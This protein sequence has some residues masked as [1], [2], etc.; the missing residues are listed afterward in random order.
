MKRMVTKLFTV[1]LI[2]LALTSFIKPKKWFVLES[3]QYG[4]KIEFPRKPSESPQV[5]NSAI[6][7]LK[8]NIF[9]YDASETGKDDNLVYMV[10]YTEYPD[11]LINSENTEILADFFRNSIDGAVTNVHGK[12]L[13]LISQVLCQINRND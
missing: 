2:L 3:E 10:S 13:S 4:Y 7:E 12:L 11:T 5:V 6:G 1:S 9:I 8:M